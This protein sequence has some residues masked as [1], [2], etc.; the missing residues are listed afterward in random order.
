MK[1]L[2]LATMLVGAV[3]LAQVPSPIDP[4]TR[5]TRADF[6]ADPGTGPPPAVA[7]WSRQS[8]PDD[9]R[10]NHPDVRHPGWYRMSFYVDPARGGPWL[11]YAPHLRDG[12]R[13]FLNGE[14][15]AGVRESDA[16]VRVR[17]TRPHLFAMRARELRPGANTLLVRVPAPP[18]G[19]P[20]WVGGFTVGPEAMVRP[21]HERRL[22]AVSTMPLLMAALSGVMGLFVLSIWAL[23]RMER[24]YGLFGAGL[25]CWAVSALLYVV[26]VVPQELFHLWRA[27][28]TVALGGFVVSMVLFMLRFVGTRWPAY[29]QA[30]IGYFALGALAALAGGPTL[31]PLVDAFW[32]LGLVPL[33]LVAVYAIARGTWKLRT[34][35]VA[36]MLF[37]AA[38]CVVAGAHDQFVALGWLPLE[39]TPLLAFATLVLLSVMG[40]LLVDRFI[41]ALRAAESANTWL[42]TRV[43]EKER[44]L[45][46]NFAR[47]R[48]AEDQQ[49]RLA[50]R[51]RIMQDVHDGI[52]SQLLTSLGMIERG[53]IGPADVAQVLREAIDDLRLVIDML[54]PEESDFVAALGN[55]RYRLEPRFAAAG[56]RMRW[57]VRG[58][59]ETVA[60]GPERS[61]QVLRILQECFANIAKH[62]QAREVQVRARLSPEDGSVLEL[63][64]EDD[65][66]GLDEDAARP[67]QRHGLANM[68]RRAQALGA[69]LEFPPCARGTRVALRVPVLPAGAPPGA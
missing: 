53:A 67:G 62:A 52:G 42:E 22:F 37:A 16:E 43:A 9:W 60:L 25:V 32:Q 24:V 7:P 21:L 19:D 55:L 40:A 58:L 68:R 13:V 3:A 46:A 48:A 44:E 2:V 65:G 15:L 8:L 10:K 6:V 34:M 12:A 63:A 33:A 66:V 30:A 14:L 28:H 36:A 61:L 11:L 51:Q 45:A 17:W 23:R 27:V 26:E 49:V 31:Q 69:T 35:E 5:F 18:A 47:L 64:V 29:E 56:I 57:D 1:G 20:G 38:L 50:E 4:L 54:T 41:R 39:N 59:P